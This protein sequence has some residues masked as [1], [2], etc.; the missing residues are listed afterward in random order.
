[1]A[2]QTSLITFT[3][4]LGN[5][6]GY[7]RK[8]HY[9]LRSAPETVRQTEN[10]R[11]AAER[12]GIASKKGALI[13]HALYE[14]LDVLCDGT[15]VNRLNKAFIRNGRNYQAALTDFRFNQHTGI[16]RF[17]SAAPVCS[18]E[19]TVH[20]PAQQLPIIKG[21]T[22]LE[23]KVICA[24]ISF[25][26]HQIIHTRTDRM[27]LQP[28]AYFA[29]NLLQVDV[30]GTGILVVMVQ[31]RAL[32]HEL[33]SGDRNYMAADI[34]AVFPPERAHVYHHYAVREDEIIHRWSVSL[35]TDACQHPSPSVIRRE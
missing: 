30:P 12:F 10:T 3:G 6:I 11:R 5:M 27:M 16:D 21:F 31:V 24:R 7:Q 20:I 18:P 2:K 25:A 33:P 15:H 26:T 29:G 17:F 32:R 35:F 14:E 13:R 9:F 23:V 8:Q 34:I 19:G 28:G 4:K 22:A 1:M